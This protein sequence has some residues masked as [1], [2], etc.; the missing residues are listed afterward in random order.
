MGPLTTPDLSWSTRIGPVDLTVRVPAPCQ[1]RAPGF[2]V[3][4]V[5]RLADRE[6]LAAAEQLAEVESAVH[7]ERQEFLARRWPSL[8]A[9]ADLQPSER[10]TIPALYQVHKAVSRTEPIP[11]VGHDVLIALSEQDWGAEWDALVERCR[12]LAAA[13]CDAFAPALARCAEEVATAVRQDRVRHAVFV[14]HPHF[15]RDILVGHLGEHTG[16]VAAG[17]ELVRA[18]RRPL[19]TVHRYLRRFATRCETVS[20]FGPATFARFDP[21]EPDA[22]RIDPPGA[23]ESF[24]EAS[25]WLTEELLARVTDQVAMTE[26]LVWRQPLF[27]EISGKLR[28]VLTGKSYRVRPESL[29][30]WRAADG[31]RT[32]GEAAVAAGVDLAD[33]PAAVRGLGPAIR[34]APVALPATEPRPTAV[35]AAVGADTAPDRIAVL[36]RDFAR[37][38]WPDRERHYERLE[39]A[40]AELGIDVRRNDGQHYAD[41]ELLHEDRSGPLSEKVTFGGPTVAALRKAIDTVLPICYLGALLRREDARE[42]LRAATG[43]RA[44]PFAELTLRDLDVPEPRWRLLRTRLAELVRAHRVGDV[45]ELSSAQVHQATAD[46]WELVD[47]GSRTD[48]CFPSPDFMIAGPELDGGQWVLSELHDDCSTVYGGIETQVHSTPSALFETFTDAVRR[49]LGDRRMATIISRRRNAHITPELP[50]LSLE[51]SGL[52]RQSRG[53]TRPIAD[54]VLAADACQVLVDGHPVTLYPGDL[55]SALHRSVALPSVTPVPIEVGTAT[56]RVVIDGLVYQR[57]RWRT[58]LPRADRG[59]SFD[60]WRTMVAVRRAHGLPRRVFVRHPAEPKPFY[61]DFADPV[62]LLDLARLPPGE[63]VVTEMLPEPGRLWWGPGA[64][65]QCAE[66]RVGVL[67]A[68]RNHEE[69]IP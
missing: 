38:P 63:V 49:L 32:L 52:S 1:V 59:S 34:T 27:A 64:G 35:L 62:A 61:V 13:M 10:R 31:A 24:V 43:E 11:P 22:V 42:A 9:A 36:L 28:H 57:A 66:L 56:P 20:F 39:A 2:P 26:R 54:A 60:R 8:R 6:L 40:V 65:R 33:L 12:A 47:S 5:D 4:I 19:L 41:R 58:T 44:V 25:A 29:R 18:V 45:V 51:L 67:V 7:R 30:L 48:P 16:P 14:S 50:G 53:L 17:G 46:L 68:G 23:E 69:G 55:S 37:A 3:G 21:A 15:Y